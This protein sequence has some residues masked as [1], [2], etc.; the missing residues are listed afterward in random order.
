MLYMFICVCVFSFI[1]VYRAL[2]CAIFVPFIDILQVYV[3]KKDRYIDVYGHRFILAMS[4][5]NITL[6]I[7][8]QV[9]FNGPCIYTGGRVKG[10]SVVTRD[11]FAIKWVEVKQQVKIRQT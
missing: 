4:K 6:I 5:K 2:N 1:H 11:L 3:R 8:C 9:L 10:R 7:P